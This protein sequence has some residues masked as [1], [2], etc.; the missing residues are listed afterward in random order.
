VTEGSETSL[1]HQ[2]AEKELPKICFDRIMTDEILFYDSAFEQDCKVFC[3]RRNITFLPSK[4]DCNVCYNLVGEE[5]RERQIEESQRVEAKSEIFDATVLGKFRKHHV[6]FVYEKS[7]IVGVVHFC[8]Y[9][10]DPVFLNLYPLLLRFERKLRGLLTSSGL[11]DEDMLKFFEAHAKDDPFYKDRFNRFR[12]SKIEKKM[13]ELEPFQM[14]DLKDLIALANSRKIL[15]IPETINDVRNTIMHS[16]NVVK[17]RDYEVANLIY[18]FDSFQNF[19][20]SV[21]QIKLKIKEIKGKP[22]NIN[23][24]EEVIRLKK[25]GLFLRFRD[26][27]RTGYAHK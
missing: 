12:D 20:N 11:Q 9:N 3:Q 25:A 5:F 23:D 2:G 15:K 6:L 4:K 7:E 18:D 13:K 22:P 24:S 26:W 19:F 17:H 16:K 21:K 1:E 10:R 8:D 27:K 14:F